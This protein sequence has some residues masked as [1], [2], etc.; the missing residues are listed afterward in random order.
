MTEA[1]DPVMV[2][3]FK[4]AL[5]LGDPGGGDSDDGGE[6]IEGPEPGALAGV[7]VGGAGGEL[8]GAPWGGVEMEVGAGA[9]AEAGGG[10]VGEWD[11]VDVGDGGGATALGEGAAALGE[12][13]GG[14]LVGEPVGAAPGAWAKA[15]PDTKAKSSINHTKAEE[16]IDILFQPLTS[17][18]WSRKS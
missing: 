12:E 10:I 9:G 14:D 7:G 1:I 18:S 4:A 11:G 3:V 6:L 8:V 13:A 17:Q 15:E 2:T 5:L 16:A